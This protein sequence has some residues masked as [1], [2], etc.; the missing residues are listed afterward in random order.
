MV[1]L[2]YNLTAISRLWSGPINPPRYAVS[3]HHPYLLGQRHFVYETLVFLW[4]TAYLKYYSPICA[5][6][7]KIWGNI[8]ELDICF[9]SMSSEVVQGCMWTIYLFLTGPNWKTA[10]ILFWRRYIYLS[11]KLNSSGRICSVL[12]QWF[13]WLGPYGVLPYYYHWINPYLG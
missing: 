2:T 9:R 13:I 6:S 5:A 8:S 3:F 12:A 10:L 11:G 7:V 4:S 1:C